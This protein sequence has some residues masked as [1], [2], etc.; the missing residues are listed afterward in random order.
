[1]LTTINVG[2]ATDGTCA[3]S[4][5]VPAGGF[6][7][8]VFCI[9]ALGYTSM[10]QAQGCESGGAHGG[11]TVWDG[12]AACPDAEVSRVGDTSDPADNA[13]GTLSTGCTTAGAGADT[14]GNINTTRGDTVCD[15]E[16]G[17]QT[18]L[19]I[20][21]LSTTWADENAECPDPDGMFDGGDLIITQFNFILSPTSRSS[22]ADYTD[23][24]ADGC[25][26][27]GSGPDHSKRCSDDFSLPCAANINCGRCSVSTAQRCNA[28]GVASGCPAAET[29]VAGSCVDGPLEGSPAEGPCCTVGQSTTVV[30]NGIAFTGAGPLFDIIF[31]N[32]TPSSI[33]QCNPLPT[34]SD[35]CV[36]TTN[37]CQ[38]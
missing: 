22:I 33:T 24:N 32:S 12:F 5:T 6:T 20:P 2:P 3:H 14:A 15:A 9:P 19:D 26:F 16:P 7:V 37:S 35:T 13:C 1:V 27:A 38:D 34:S 31:N 8:P 30:A 25:S 11:G 29:C 36:L 10:V 18:Q 4:V 28:P 21:V 17:V 23:L